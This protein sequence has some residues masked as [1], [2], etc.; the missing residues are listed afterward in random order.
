MK[1][2]TTV[3][4][5]TAVMTLSA[6]DVQAQQDTGAR[7]PTRAEVR[8]MQPTRAQIKPSQVP[9]LVA[10]SKAR[11]VPA[12]AKQTPG[13]GGSAMSGAATTLAAPP[14]S[15]LENVTLTVRRMYTGHA[16]LAFR[17]ATVS[18]DN[19]YA[20]WNDDIQNVAFGYVMA[21]INVKAGK[22]YLLDFE[23]TANEP[24][25]FGINVGDTKQDIAV[26]S[27]KRNLLA[28][29]DATETTRVVGLLNSD[30]ANYVFHSLT[31]T[32][33]D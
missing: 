7:K 4:I 29:V 8:Q 33:V 12:W 9:V 5:L 22:R 19:N 2:I 20:F 6:N 30:S 24:T 17:L 21:G 11:Q 13:S 28:Y 18:S 15:E 16:S 3:V 31:I 32:R 26:G 14:K 10:S 1:R 23:I 27:G 25:T